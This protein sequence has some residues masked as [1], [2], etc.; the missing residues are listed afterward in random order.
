M[1]QAV[2]LLTIALGVSIAVIC[3]QI[4]NARRA[5][6]RIAGQA[7]RIRLLEEAIEQQRE[8]IAWHVSNSAQLEQRK[9]LLEW[10]V[11]WPITSPRGPS[12]TGGRR[13]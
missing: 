13:W 9:A 7:Q 12:A 1:I 8:R 11:G 2:V 10:S 4:A 6:R 5:D 3:E